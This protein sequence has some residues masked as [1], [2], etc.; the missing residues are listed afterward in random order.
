M[1]DCVPE[2]DFCLYDT[3][4]TKNLL[5]LFPYF[6]LNSTKAPLLSYK[7]RRQALYIAAPIYEPYNLISYYY[8]IAEPYP[9]AEPYISAELY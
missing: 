8:V 7:S 4:N 9:G 2:H 3:C 6:I 1:I 5:Q